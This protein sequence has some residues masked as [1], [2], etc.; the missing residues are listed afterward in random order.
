MELRHFNLELSSFCD[1]QFLRD[2]TDAG[3]LPRF[4]PDQ[5][6][7]LRL[8]NLRI[9]VTAIICLEKNPAT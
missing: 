6:V 5:F 4:P 8:C 7:E 1:Y 3:G 9:S 2:A